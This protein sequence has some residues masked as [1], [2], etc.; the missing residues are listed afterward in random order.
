MALIL[1]VRQPWYLCFDTYETGHDDLD[2]ES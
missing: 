1:T 2:H